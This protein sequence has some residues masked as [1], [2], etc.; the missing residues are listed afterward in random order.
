MRR[1]VHRSARSCHVRYLRD[2]KQV[3]RNNLCIKVLSIKKCK[4]IQHVLQRPV[5]VFTLLTYSKNCFLESNIL[6]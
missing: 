6:T 2:E 4:L 1:I 3:H 5:F